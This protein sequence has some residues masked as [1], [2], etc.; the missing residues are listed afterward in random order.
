MTYAEILIKKGKR[1][2]AAFVQAECMS[3]KEGGGAGGSAQAPPE[4]HQTPAH[5]Q[6]LLDH[7]L[8]PEK[9]IGDLETVDWCRWTTFTCNSVLS[10]ETGWD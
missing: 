4:V 10:S 8:H 1:G 3:N 5:L 7:L 6:A 2:A 9:D